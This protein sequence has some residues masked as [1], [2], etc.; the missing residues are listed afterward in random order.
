MLQVLKS[1]DA[2]FSSL[3]QWMLLGD[4]EGPVQIKEKVDKAA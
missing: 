1:R 3:S 2:V 4:V